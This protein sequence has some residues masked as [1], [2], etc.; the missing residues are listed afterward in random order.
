[1]HIF[2]MSDFPD[3]STLHRQ[4]QSSEKRALSVKGLRDNLISNVNS[5]VF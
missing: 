4:C 1:M 2:N 5:S 3:V